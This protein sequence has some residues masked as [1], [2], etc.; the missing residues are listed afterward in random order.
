MRSGAKQGLCR[1]SF[2]EALPGS[3]EQ[4]IVG[5]EMV[6][7]ALWIIAERPAPLYGSRTPPMC[8]GSKAARTPVLSTAGTARA[9]WGRGGRNRLPGNR[10]ARSSLQSRS[11]RRSG[12][13]S[14]PRV[15]VDGMVPMSTVVRRRRVSLNCHM[16]G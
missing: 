14:K 6:I 8:S 13:P 4:S 7:L 12:W 15:Q 11:A 3:Q 2:F 10:S 5:T 16:T 9:R 1:S